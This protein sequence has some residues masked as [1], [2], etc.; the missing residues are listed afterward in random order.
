MGDLEDAEVAA[1]L[2][3]RGVTVE[4]ARRASTV[5]AIA[6]MRAAVVIVPPSD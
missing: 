5:I 3:R 1:A 6:S 2:A 4:Q